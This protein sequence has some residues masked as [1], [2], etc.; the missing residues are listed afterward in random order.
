MQSSF[1]SLS[2]SLSS[3]SSPCVLHVETTACVVERRRTECERTCVYCGRR[4]RMHRYEALSFS[5]HSQRSTRHLPASYSSVI[6]ARLSFPCK[7]SLSAVSGTTLG[8][9]RDA[10]TRRPGMF[11]W[12]RAIPG[13]AT[14]SCA[15]LK[16]PR[17]R[18]EPA[19]L[20]RC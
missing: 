11:T 3:S 4:C 15:G 14:K 10:G 2:V 18:P 19:T 6:M 16:K 17:F 8:N 5:H 9:V 20:P 13:A 1:Q 7:T 12:A